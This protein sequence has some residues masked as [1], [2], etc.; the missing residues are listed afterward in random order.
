MSKKSFADSELVVFK[1]SQGL[2]ARGTLLKLS[3]NHI[4][5]EVY[6]PYSIVQLSEVLTDLTIT[7]LEREIY[8]GKAIV[9]NI[10]NTGVILVVSAS[11]SDSNW[12]ELIRYYSVDDIHREA[13]QLIE[14][15]ESLQIVD[16][17][18]AVNIFA[19]RSFLSEVKSWFDKLEPYFEDKN[20][21]AL[22]DQVV[23][24]YFPQFFEKLTLLFRKSSELISVIPRDKVEVYKKII[25]TYL[26]PLL[27]SSDRK[28]VV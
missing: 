22:D 21:S 15:F 14:S 27:M 5:F 8:S 10:V 9:T 23:L 3:Q 18:I 7:R 12:R 24:K 6:N 13:D 19:I 26:H 2:K 28:S 11:L 1:N 20:N 16:E 17:K 25:Q 4:V